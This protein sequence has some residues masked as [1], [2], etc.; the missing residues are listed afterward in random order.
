[1]TLQASAACFPEGA[2]LAGAL[3]IPIDMKDCAVPAG[4]VQVALQTLEAVAESSD[5]E[6]GGGALSFAAAVPGGG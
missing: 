2:V 6:I 3:L 1:M 5:G 4:R